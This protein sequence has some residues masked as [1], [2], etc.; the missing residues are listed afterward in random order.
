M[1]L[2]IIFHLILSFISFQT[3]RAIAAIHPRLET[4]TVNVTSNSTVEVTFL[5]VL[6]CLQ[7]LSIKSN[8]VHDEWGYVC[9]NTTP[10]N[11]TTLNGKKLKK[12]ELVH[13]RPTHLSLQ[14]LLK[15][16]SNLQE[17]V[18][19]TC[20]FEDWS[21]IFSLA[22]KHKMLKRLELSSITVASLNYCL[23]EYFDHLKYLKLKDCSLPTQ[24]FETFFSLCSE[25]E[26]V[27]LESIGN[28]NDNVIL[29]LLQSSE[30]LKKLTLN[31]CPSVTDVTVDHIATY[32]LMLKQLTI[33]NC[34]VTNEALK[35][36]N[37]VSN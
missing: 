23:S 6:E 18:L 5:D 30:R 4:I 21:E 17:I 13:I 22:E 28:V 2:L 15:E 35:K 10:V 31:K 27:V 20:Y 24:L 34:N 26:D 11:F 9:R 16:S 33:K 37:I 36:L 25:L 29:D 7:T 19:D 32:G 12:L 1:N 14:R 3:L 8:I